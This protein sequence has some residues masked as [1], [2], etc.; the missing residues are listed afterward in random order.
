M[1]EVIRTKFNTYIQ[2]FKENNCE[3]TTTFEEYCERLSKQKYKKSTAVRVDYIASCGHK[4]NVAITN[5]MSRK[6]GLLCKACVNVNTKNIGIEKNK[7]NTLTEL[8]GYKLFEKYIADKYDVCRTNEGCTADILI[9]Y[10]DDTD[11]NW[12]PIQLKV[13]FF[14]LCDFQQFFV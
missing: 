2:C 13:L 7:V 11:N 4:N 8:H 3:V 1:S 14:M 5:F 9:K 6:T 10:K 12:I